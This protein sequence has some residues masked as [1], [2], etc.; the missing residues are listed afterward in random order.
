MSKAFYQRRYPG[1][2]H[3]VIPVWWPSGSAVRPSRDR[4]S[5]PNDPYPFD[6]VHPYLCVG[7]SC[8]MQDDPRPEPCPTSSEGGVTTYQIV[9]NGPLDQLIPQDTVSQAWIAF[10][11]LAL[12]ASQKAEEAHRTPCARRANSWLNMIL[13]VTICHCMLLLKYGALR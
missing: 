1:N 8:H 6:C 10:I 2:L 4:S 12:S 3:L 5:H 9:S 13:M 7:V 11:L